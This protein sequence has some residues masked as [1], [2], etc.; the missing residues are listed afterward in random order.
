VTGSTILIVDDEPTNLTVLNQLLSP[1]HTVRACRS[2]E[3][4]LRAAVGD[5][6][7]DLILLDVMMPG[8]DG[9]AVIEELRSDAR[10]SDIPVIFVTALD[11]DVEEERGLALGAVDYITKP[12]TPAV[13]QARV[14]AHLEIKQARD[15]LRSQNDWLEAEVE[16]RMREN[17]LVQ[18]LSLG[19]L[20]ELAETR[21][22]DTGNHIL[23][24]K[25]FIGV[26]A[27]QLHATSSYRPQLAEPRLTRIVKASPLHDIGKVAIP[28]RILLKPGKLTPEE[29]A[30]MKTHARIGGEVIRRA[31]QKTLPVDRSA[32]VTKPES[33]AFLE[34]AGTIATWHH[35]RW[36]GSG[37]PDGLSGSDIPLPARLMA[38]ADVY[39]ALTAPRVYKRPWTLDEAAEHLRRE[40]G[41]HFD[42]EIVDAFLT[43]RRDFETI[44]RTL[45]D[46]EPREGGVLGGP[47]WAPAA[48]P[49]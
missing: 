34:T 45:R 8:M 49:A 41:T 16:R 18:E 9:Y 47:A 29:W 35:E 11:D 43:V 12:I 46:E 17:L 6:Q 36:D 30:V 1:E 14:R 19:L 5:P 13:V 28:D 31:I 15:R 39:D 33:L 24:T 27:R 4:A 40:A 32:A 2:G 25:A 48:G 7:P 22:A 10:T 38:L 44:Q 3:Q 23:R 26:L 21:D 42:P 37:Y 20:A